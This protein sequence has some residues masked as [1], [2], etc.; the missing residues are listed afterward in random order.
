MKCAGAI[1][2]ACAAATALA[3]NPDALIKDL[4]GWAGG[5]FDQYSGYITVN[6][7]QG[8]ALFYWFVEATS[9]PQDKPVVVWT[10]GG[11]GCSSVGGG[12][13]TE[14]GPFFAQADGTLKANP[15]AWNTEANVIFLEHPVGVGFSYSNDTKFYNDITDEEDAAD[16]YTFMK[17]WYSQFPEY[18]SNPLWIT[19]ESYGGHYVPHFTQKI[20]Q[21]NAAAAAGVAGAVHMNIQGFMVG[22]AWTVA[23]LDN[24]GAVFY[25][26]THGL[27]SDEN[28]LG[29]FKACNM[30]NVGP[31]RR[32]KQ[33]GA[34]FLPALQMSE[35]A[36]AAAEAAGHTFDQSCTYYQNAIFE[37]FNNV[38]IYD[39]YADVCVAADG[40]KQLKPQAAAM[41]KAAGRPVPTGGL[42]VT[43][44]TDDDDSSAT[45]AADNKGGCWSGYEPCI[46]SYV[47]TYLNRA[48]VQAAIHARPTQ[49]TDCSNIINYDRTSLLTSMLPVY[50]YLMSQ[51]LKL[52]VYSGDVDAIVPITGT[53]TWIDALN[54]QTAEPW[55]PYMVHDQ[56]GGF[57]Q[58]YKGLTFAS[59]RNAGHLVP[60]TQPAR[61][62]HMFKAFL[63]G[64]PL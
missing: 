56:V 45:H 18:A 27:I 41:L 24:A 49:W 7:T 64:K 20:A 19:G 39:I 10:N 57:V 48:D 33:G 51:N 61:A 5:S 22:N 13:M 29:I 28:Y 37:S 62:H 21:E 11:P 25:D 38:D 44:P 8:R 6:E 17:G 53:R 63:N 9:N 3:A 1:L 43:G 54:L 47:N 2:L 15:W 31:L 46:S 14:L 30:S 58:E 42:K 36:L 60:G 55:R 26:W 16:F 4:P 35:A 23:E 50:E 32:L 34:S 12:L 52:L 40:T 59:V